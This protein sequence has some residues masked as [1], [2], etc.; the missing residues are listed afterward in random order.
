MKRDSSAGTFQGF[1]ALRYVGAGLPE[2]ANSI[3]PAVPNA[4]FAEYANG[5]AWC[6]GFQEGVQAAA[7]TLVPPA[8]IPRTPSASENNAG[9]VGGGWRSR[10]R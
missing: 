10:S 9:L 7:F 4:L 2:E 5:E 6:L 3:S 8:S 1:I